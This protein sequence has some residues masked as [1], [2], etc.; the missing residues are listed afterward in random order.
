MTAV[1]NNTDLIENVQYNWQLFKTWFYTTFPEPFKRSGWI[2]Q[3]M[4][5]IQRLVPYMCGTRTWSLLC[6]EMAWNLIM[7]GNQQ[8][9]GWLL[10]RTW[11]QMLLWPWWLRIILC[12]SVILWNPITLQG[13]SSVV[14][15]V[16]ILMDHKWFYVIPQTF[17]SIVLEG[18]LFVVGYPL[19]TVV[20]IICAWYH[21]VHRLT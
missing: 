2:D 11:C 15:C 7:S 18:C 14:I 13:F 19:V 5:T 20:N 17:Y 1:P 6:P 12:W 3:K 4:S 10:S 8:S 21:A 9:H 16:I